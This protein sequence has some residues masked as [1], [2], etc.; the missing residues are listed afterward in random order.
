M[1]GSND[2]ATRQAISPR[3]AWAEMREH[4]LLLADVRCPRDFAS[5]HV[6]GSV[7]APLDHLPDEIEGG[8]VAWVNDGLPV[9]HG[10]RELYLRRL[11]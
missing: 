8:L 7:N 4:A 5:G 2:T 1:S 3:R 9:E 11:P 6:P 10:W